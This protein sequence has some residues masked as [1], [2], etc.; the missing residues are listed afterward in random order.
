MRAVHLVGRY[1]WSLVGHY[2]NTNNVAQTKHIVKH[3]VTQHYSFTEFCQEIVNVENTVSFL[4]ETTASW[5]IK[6]ITVSDKNNF[7]FA[8][9]VFRSFERSRTDVN[10]YTETHET[11]SEFATQQVRKQLYKLT[12][13]APGFHGDADDGGREPVFAWVDDANDLPA[14]IDIA[15]TVNVRPPSIQWIHVVHGQPLP[16]NAEKLGTNYPLCRA[17]YGDL[18]PGFVNSGKAEIAYGNKRYLV[19]EYD[20]MVLGQG[21]ALEYMDNTHIFPD[22]AHAPANVLRVGPAGHPVCR[23][24][25]PESKPAFVNGSKAEVAHGN[26]RVLVPAWQWVCLRYM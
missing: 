4:H 21:V 19:H 7:T 3:T 11:T 24:N 1:K 18:R 15:I 8:N 16:L 10:T 13:N 17:I 2:N 22:S 26:D 14:L 6:D 23:V 5:T 20:V 9:R 12:L 25:T